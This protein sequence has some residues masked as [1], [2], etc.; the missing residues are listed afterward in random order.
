MMGCVTKS[1]L[2]SRPETA[3]R[4]MHQRFHFRDRP[5]KKNSNAR[6]RIGSWIGLDA[7]GWRTKSQ[8][9]LYLK[10]NGVWLGNTV[11]CLK[12]MVKLRSV[13]SL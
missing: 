2:A 7:A 5:D 11:S 9:H 13:D 6:F 3:W 10:Q 4:Q 12:T 8:H 1:R